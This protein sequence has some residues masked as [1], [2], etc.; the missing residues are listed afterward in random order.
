MKNPKELTVRQIKTMFKE[1]SLLSGEIFKLTTKEILLS[2][3]NEYEKDLIYK[4]FE[5][6]KTMKKL[7]VQIKM[8][9]IKNSKN[10]VQ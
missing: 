5:A 2:L 8:Q 9:E 7:K 3:E 6:Y 4:L 10:T 1:S